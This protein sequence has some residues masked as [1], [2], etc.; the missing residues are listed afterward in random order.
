MC[1]GSCSL[2]S[3]QVEDWIG[4]ETPVNIP[5]TNTEYPNWRRK[6]TADLE[7]IFVNERVLNMTK[8]MTEARG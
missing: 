1:G 7:D 4:V 3:S 5:G 8:K 6:L 2:F